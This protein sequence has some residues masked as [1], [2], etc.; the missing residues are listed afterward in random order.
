MIES[1]LGKSVAANLS[2]GGTVDG[3]LTI[4]GDLGV[5]GDVSINLTSVVSNSTIIDATGTEAFLVRKNSDGGD[6]FVVDSTNTRVGIGDSTPDNTLS[7]YGGNKQIRMGATDSNYL[8]IGRNSSTGHFEMGRTCTGAAD[9]IFFRANEASGGNISFPTGNVGIG[10]SD[11]TSDLDIGASGGGD[12]TLSRTGDS[13]IT[14]GSNLGVIYFKGHDDS[15]SNVQPATGA[16]IV[17]QSAG[18]WDQDDVDDA[19]TELQFWT[20]NASG[21]TS[22]AQRMVIDADGNVGIGLSTLDTPLDITPRLQ[23]EGLNASTSSISLF[24]NSNDAHPPYLLLGK[25]RG[26]AVNADTVIQDNDVLGKIAFVG[27]DGTDR[28][29]SGAEIFARI[30][31]TPGGNDLPT[32]LV[33]GTT[34]DGGTTPTERMSIDASGTVMIDQNANAIALN[35]DHEGTNQQAINVSAHRCR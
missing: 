17:G 1:V 15:G 11:P 22:I 28:H 8:L 7:I 5:A 25:S 34:A 4:T 24:R 21:G 31:G 12:L 9:E 26:T 33:F 35:I 10:T 6:V 30:N 19:P 13:N 32:E 14:D 18:H 29:N 16:K 20:C 23:V 2:T 27:A 3:D